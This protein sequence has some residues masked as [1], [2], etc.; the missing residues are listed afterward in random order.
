MKSYAL[1]AVAAGVT[2]LS[3][4]ALA[5]GMMG[6]AAATTTASQAAGSPAA[7]MCAM[8]AAATQSPADAGQS[9]QPGQAPA[10]S[11]GCPCC[12]AMAVVQPR[13]GRQGVMPGMGG[14]NHQGMPGMQHDTPAAPNPVSPAPETPKPGD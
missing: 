11:G 14:M 5:C 4:P 13:P 1:A 2:F 9:A 12:R 3:A 10:M 7:S 6:N 8:P